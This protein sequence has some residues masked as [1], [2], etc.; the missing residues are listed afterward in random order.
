MLLLRDEFYARKR[1]LEAGNAAEHEYTASRKFEAQCRLMDYFVRRLQEDEFHQGIFAY[2]LGTLDRMMLESLENLYD[3]SY[4]PSPPPPLAAQRLESAQ[5]L[6]RPYIIKIPKI[7][8][9][10]RPSLKPAEQYPQLSR[11]QSP[12]SARD[13][14]AIR[15][16]EAFIQRRQREEKQVERQMQRAKQQREWAREELKRRAVKEKQQRKAEQE[17]TKQE[18]ERKKLLQ[19]WEKKVRYAQGDHK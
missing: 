10:P 5:P 6:R 8:R 7:Q 3:V 19:K 17:E 12:E 2:F 14:R 13:A 16:K 1:R 9:P 11:L 4:I 18:K 15:I